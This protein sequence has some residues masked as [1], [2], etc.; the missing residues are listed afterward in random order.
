MAVA[1]SIAAQQ[2][3]RIEPGRAPRG[4][5]RRDRDQ[6]E[7]QRDGASSTACTALKM[8]LVA[9][10]ASARMAITAD[11]YPGRFSR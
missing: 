8:P 6:A 2:R 3:R 5:V 1:A 4:D 11:E 10:M 9:A 7:N